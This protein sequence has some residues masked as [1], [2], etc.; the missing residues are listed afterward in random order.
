MERKAIADL[1]LKRLQ[2]EKE[3]LKQQFAESHSGIGHLYIDNLLPE[4]LAHAIHEAFP[5][6]EQMVRK[7]TLR[8]Y[9][10]IA[11][12]MDQ[13]D[14]LL[15]EA[16]YAFQ[17][18]R[19]VV[20]VGEICGIEG[21]E[22][23]ENLYAGGISLMA[24]DNYLNPHLDNSHDKDRDRW[25]ILNLLFYVTPNWQDANGGH[26]E[27]WPEGL[28]HPQ[29]TIH[30]RFNRLA[31]M[32][33]HNASWHSV[34]PVVGE[35]DRCCVSNYYFSKRPLRQ[36]DSFHVT[37]FRARPGNKFKDFVLDSDTKLR[38]ILRKVFR[39]GIRENPHQYKKDQ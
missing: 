23:D 17:D 25:R 18:K 29:V 36:D 6:K 4:T 19:I 33:T 7:K 35:G 3:R 9:K 21:L 38:M 14:P 20:L 32:A 1:I 2:E 11:A 28:D 10:Y 15:E 12:Q 39:K 30:S 16:I 26:L 27:V 34:S 37:S 31:I 8:E 22:P 13:Y 24:K 5:K